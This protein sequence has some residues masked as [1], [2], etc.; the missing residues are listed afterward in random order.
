MNAA[1]D[2]VEDTKES[3]DRLVV[4]MNEKCTRLDAFNIYQGN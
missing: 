4:G 3:E 1:D 2:F